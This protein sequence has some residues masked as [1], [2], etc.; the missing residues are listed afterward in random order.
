VNGNATIDDKGERKKLR[1]ADFSN[2]KRT[3]LNTSRSLCH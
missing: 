3:A 1:S 2:R